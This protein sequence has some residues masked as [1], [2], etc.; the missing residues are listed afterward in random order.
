MI[1]L[2]HLSFFNKNNKFVV[3]S[4]TE[5]EATSMGVHCTDRL[6]RWLASPKLYRE[7][8]GGNASVDADWFSAMPK[9]DQLFCRLFEA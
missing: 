9:C 8:H 3:F 7:D 5:L 4:T 1:L 6:Q 2:K